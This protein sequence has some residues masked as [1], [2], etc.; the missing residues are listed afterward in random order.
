MNEEVTRI[1]KQYNRGVIT[2]E[3]AVQKT[4]SV[5]NND[6]GRLCKI[7]NNIIDQFNNE[8]TGLIACLERD[9]DKAVISIV[10]EKLTRDQVIS[11]L[12]AAYKKRDAWFKELWNTINVLPLKEAA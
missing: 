2:N 3:E 9:Q 6:L 10:N 1:C 4:L 11:R 12:C 8:V 7:S 5:M